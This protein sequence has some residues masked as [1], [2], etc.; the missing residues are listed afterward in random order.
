MQLV[1]I[2]DLHIGGLF[3]KNVF[4]MIVDEVNN[5]KPTAIIISGD[6]TD[7]GLIFQFQ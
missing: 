4:D 5:L 3:K 2:S 6:L 1:Q 7:D